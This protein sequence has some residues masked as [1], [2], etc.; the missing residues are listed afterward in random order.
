MEI[1]QA[2][3]Y[4]QQDAVVEHYA[5]ATNAVGL[6]VSE[7]KIFTRLFKRSDS[8]L[9]LGCGAGRICI[10][11]WEL[12]YQHLLGIDYSREMITEAR[13]INQVLEYG[14]A[15]HC[16]DATQLDFD[17][18]T[19]DGAIFGFNGLQM[20]PGRENRRRAMREVH[21]VLKPG[22]WFVFTGHDRESHGTKKLWRDQAK[23]W[24]RNGQ[25]PGLE[26]FGELFHD[27]PEGGQM[28]IYSAS[29][30]EILDDLAAAGLRHETDI[31]RSE[32]CSEPAIVR[33]FSDDTRFWI[34]QRPSA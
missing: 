31:L 2:K 34:V 27:M 4:F 21:R 7:E 17:D 30:G 24:Q 3:P 14:V 15:F 12:G 6:W 29:R 13:R 10:G 11:L 22:G 26:M 28:Y 18:A 16:Q 23:L 1:E 8:L 20:I 32:L 33:Q 25:H 9:E 19:Y 5:R